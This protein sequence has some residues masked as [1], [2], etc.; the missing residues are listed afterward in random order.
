MGE[1]ELSARG[2]TF[3]YG[4]LEAKDNCLIIKDVVALGKIKSQQGES[5]SMTVVLPGFEKN[6]QTMRV[7]FL[8]GKPSAL[9]LTTFDDGETRVSGDDLK[10]T[11]VFQNTSEISLG[12]E[13]VDRSENVTSNSKLKLMAK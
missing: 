3:E 4:D 6:T 1:P 5:F 12:V 2:L 10:S 13:L 7:R 8:P 9:K 11:L